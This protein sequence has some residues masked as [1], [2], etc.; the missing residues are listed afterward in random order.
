MSYIVS[1]ETRIREEVYKAAELYYLFELDK[2]RF[3][4]RPWII[5]ATRV[6]ICVCLLPIAI[7]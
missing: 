3:C 2:D 6:R 4:D 7:T 1:R 5:D